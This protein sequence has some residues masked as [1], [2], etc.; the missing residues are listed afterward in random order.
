MSCIWEPTGQTD[1]CSGVSPAGVA[2]QSWLITATHPS[3]IVVY[4]LQGSSSAFPALPNFLYRPT[5]AFS[6]SISAAICASSSD[7][8]GAGSGVLRYLWQVSKLRIPVQNEVRRGFN[9]PVWPEFPKG[10]ELATPGCNDD[11]TYGLPSHG[12]CSYGSAGND[13]V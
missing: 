5:F 6:A 10:P 7:V 12:L 1:K 8:S 11:C 4:L 9:I 13:R 3:F 2:A